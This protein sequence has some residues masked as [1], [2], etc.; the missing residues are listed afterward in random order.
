MV[1]IIEEE[2]NTNVLEEEDNP[3]KDDK[4][5]QRDDESVQLEKGQ[6]NPIQESEEQY[7]NVDDELLAKEEV[8]E[9]TPG[10]SSHRS[11]DFL[12]V[13]PT[14]ASS[15]HMPSEFVQF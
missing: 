1:E 15:S 12:Q 13:E 11:N 6:E 5:P 3:A 4:Q 8:E 7:R 10:C 2:Q 14:P 9:E